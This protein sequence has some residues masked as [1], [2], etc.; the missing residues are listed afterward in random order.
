MAPRVTKSKASSK[1]PLVDTTAAAAVP[2]A[3]AEDLAGDLHDIYNDLLSAKT[4]L[5]DSIPGP[6]RRQA[7]MDMEK[8]LVRAVRL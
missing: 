3:P 6:V 7:M 2:L 1:T 5:L 8:A 4:A